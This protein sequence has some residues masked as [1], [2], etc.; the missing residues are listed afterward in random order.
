LS[1]FG[2]GWRWCIAGRRWHYGSGHIGAE[3]GNGVQQP[4]A[5]PD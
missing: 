1:A 4:P 2:I 3:R 5:M